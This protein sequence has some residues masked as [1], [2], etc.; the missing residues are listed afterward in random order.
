MDF[1]KFCL[2]ICIGGM[3]LAALLTIMVAGYGLYMAF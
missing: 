3:I 2:E 1:A